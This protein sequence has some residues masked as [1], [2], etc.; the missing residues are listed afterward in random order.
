MHATKRWSRCSIPFLFLALAVLGSGGPR[1]AHALQGAGAE[2]LRAELLADLDNLESKYLGLAEVLSQEQYSWRPDDEVRS[3]S[4]VFMHVAGSSYMLGD[5]AG[6]ESP[7][8]LGVETD[9]GE[10]EAVTDKSEVVAALR[11]SFE[12]VRNGIHA[13]PDEQLEETV[14]LFGR[15]L[16]VRAVLLLVTNHMHEHLGQMIAY[17]RRNGVAPPWSGGEQ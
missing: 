15:D 12:Y 2:G 16:T 1:P 3:V 13:V 6:F 10:F 11:H 4:E 9:I 14:S 17:T 5:A 7:A 8:E